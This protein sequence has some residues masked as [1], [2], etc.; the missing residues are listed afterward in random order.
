VFDGLHPIGSEQNV[1][2]SHKP[3]EATSW[4]TP[5]QNQGMD[6]PKL[7]KWR[8]RLVIAGVLALGVIIGGAIIGGAVGGTTAARKKTDTVTTTMYVQT[9]IQ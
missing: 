2:K 3:D 9:P 4:G 6:A 5:V 1:Y 7:K 8:T